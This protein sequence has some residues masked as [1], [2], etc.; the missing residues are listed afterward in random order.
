M[1]TA[2][3]FELPGARSDGAVLSPGKGCVGR[4]GLWS[5][6]RLGL[7]SAETFA[8]CSRSGLRWKNGAGASSHRITGVCPVGPVREV[9]GCH[10]ESGLAL[11]AMKPER[12][13]GASTLRH[14]S[15]TQTGDFS[16]SAPQRAGP[17]LM[18]EPVNP[19]HLHDGRQRE[20]LWTGADRALILAGSR[21]AR[22][23]CATALANSCSS[24]ANR[25][26]LSLD[27]RPTTRAHSCEP[28]CCQERRHR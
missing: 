20:D 21:S 11:K 19:E 27:V 3:P 28:P 22:P 8:G 16:S 26:R 5:R 1:S 24:T 6:D 23:P 12:R 10:R 13:R 2:G 17:D 9:G 7:R 25:A 15:F 4:R 18:A 14:V